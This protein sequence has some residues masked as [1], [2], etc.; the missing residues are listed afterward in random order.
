MPRRKP[1]VLK[2]PSI[3]A[4][5]FPLLA[6]LLL[7][8]PCKSP[9][10]ESSSGMAMREHNRRAGWVPSNRS[11]QNGGYSLFCRRMPHFALHLAGRDAIIRLPPTTSCERD[12]RTIP[13]HPGIGEIVRRPAVLM[14]GGGNT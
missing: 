11:A 10:P 1:L 13:W 6:L 12:G 5:S 2:G 14:D 9:C 3:P 4:S 8:R 7:L